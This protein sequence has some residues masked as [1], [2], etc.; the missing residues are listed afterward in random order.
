MTN[1]TSESIHTCSY[2]C[3]RPECIKRQRDELRDAQGAKPVGWIDEFGNVFPLGAYRPP[4]NVV[5]D[6]YKTNWKHVYAAPIAQT[7]DA[8]ELL[9]LLRDILQDWDDLHAAGIAGAY[10]ERINA[11]IAAIQRKEK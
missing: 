1:P 11:A 3:E 10:Q 5:H 6:G 7:A 4:G 9:H 8:R 2:Y